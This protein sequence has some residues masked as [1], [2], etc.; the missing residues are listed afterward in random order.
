M[1]GTSWRRSPPE[2]VAAF[3]A[4]VA[5]RPDLRARKMFGYPAAFVG[6]HLTTGLFEDRWFVRLPEDRRAELL[7]VPGAAPFAP[8]PGRPMKEYVT[9][10]PSV[11]TDPAAVEAWVDRAVDH[12]RTLPPKG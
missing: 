1:A 5:R 7:E 6:G 10:P 8:M 9:L 4:L 3:E 12:V 11:V 2:L